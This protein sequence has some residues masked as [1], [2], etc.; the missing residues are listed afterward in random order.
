MPA[1]GRIVFGPGRLSVYHCGRQSKHESKGLELSGMISHKQAA[2]AAGLGVIG[3]SSLFLHHRFGP[4]VRLATLF[5]DCPFP[6]ETRFQPLSAAAA[7]NVWIPVPAARFSAR[8]GPWYAS[9]VA[10]RS[11]KMQP[12]YEA[13]VP[14]YWPRGCM[15]HMHEGA[16]PVMKGP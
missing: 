10:F 12:A 6:V 2:C 8:N 15:R 1:E 11:G 13:P 3:K 9:E 4:R 16:V 5:T 7:A 14:A